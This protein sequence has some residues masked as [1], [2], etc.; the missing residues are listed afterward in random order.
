FGGACGNLFLKKESMRWPNC[1]GDIQQS[2]RPTR[3]SVQ[4]MARTAWFGRQRT[5]SNS[6]RTHVLIWLL[7]DSTSVQLGKREDLHLAVHHSSCTRRHGPRVSTRPR[8]TVQ[9]LGRQRTSST[10]HNARPHTSSTSVQQCA[11]QPTSSFTHPARASIQQTSRSNTHVQQFETSHGP[12]RSS[13]RRI[14]AGAAA[15]APTSTKSSSSLNE[16]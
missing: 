7:T 2:T 9:Q 16:G 1:G 4:Q 11:A 5:S 14:T 10:L 13:S 3:G 12:A 15:N 8:R 6:E